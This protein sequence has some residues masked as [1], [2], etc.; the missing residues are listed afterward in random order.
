MYSEEIHTPAKPKW[1]RPYRQ[2]ML[3]NM[4]T[5]MLA[6]IEKLKREMA[7]NKS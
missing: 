6:M 1:T 2:E 5:L 4:N 7:N 3:G